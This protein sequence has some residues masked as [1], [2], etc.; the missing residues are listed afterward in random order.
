MPNE[1]KARKGAQQPGPLSRLLMWVAFAT[2]MVLM[3]V[4]IPVFSD[5]GTNAVVGA[6]VGIVSGGFGAWIGSLLEKK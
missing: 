3:I 5:V 4:F 1:D 2:G 6:A